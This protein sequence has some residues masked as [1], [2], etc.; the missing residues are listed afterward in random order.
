MSSR[1]ASMGAT[2]AATAAAP[3]TPR[4]APSHGLCV[5]VALAL[6]DPALAAAPRLRQKAVD[7][8]DERRRRRRHHEERDAP[9][10]EARRLARDEEEDAGADHLAGDDEA[11]DLRS[12]AGRE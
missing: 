12:L 9:I 5:G 10:E 6:G 1:A 4:I 2:A 8:P 7:D 11:V 3:N